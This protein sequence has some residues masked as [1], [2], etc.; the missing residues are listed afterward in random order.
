M[1]TI[2][3]GF[4]FVMVVNVGKSV[5]VADLKART[6]VNGEFR[7]DQSIKSSTKGAIF[8]LEGQRIGTAGKWRYEMIDKAGKVLAAGTITVTRP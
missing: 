5:T 4:P 6:I 1:T 2:K 7:A 8:G 3:A